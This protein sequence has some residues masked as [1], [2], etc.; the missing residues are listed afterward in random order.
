M[1]IMDFPFMNKLVFTTIHITKL[2]LD[3]DFHIWNKSA[4][5]NLKNHIQMSNTLMQ[6]F[7]KPKDIVSVKPHLFTIYYPLNSR[8]LFACQRSVPKLHFGHFWIVHVY[9]LVLQR[10]PWQNYNN[11]TSLFQG[12]FPLFPQNMM[13]SFM[14]H[15]NQFYILLNCHFLGTPYF[16][17]CKLV[18]G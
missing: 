10:N 5:I 16:F 11:F 3:A 2:K 1:R 9:N 6:V 18:S 13:P 4:S 14:L 8:V 12:F 17:F 7:N 15:T